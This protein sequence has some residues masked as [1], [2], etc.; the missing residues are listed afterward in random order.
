M[1]PIS[2]VGQLTDGQ[3]LAHPAGVPKRAGQGE[4]GTSQSCMDV[5]RIRSGVAHATYS[6]PIARSRLG[7]AFVKASA[8]T[9]SSGQAGMGR[10][11]GTTLW[12]ALHR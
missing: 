6:G 12:I 4:H 2:F 9:Q 7:I 3:S 11:R 1:R 10:W 5:A 8:L